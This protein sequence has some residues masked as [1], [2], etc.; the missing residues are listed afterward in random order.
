LQDDIRKLSLVTRWLQ[1][2]LAAAIM[3]HRLGW[4]RLGAGYKVISDQHMLT[5]LIGNMVSALAQFLGAGQSKLQ[6]GL[7]DRGLQIRPLLALQK[8][9]PVSPHR[10]S[11]W[12]PA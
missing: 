1:Q 6:A 4:N 3:W 11:L 2:S 10:V 8:P 7:A 12:W 9:W 5:K